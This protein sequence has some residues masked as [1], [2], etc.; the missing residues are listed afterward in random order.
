MN[1]FKIAEDLSH[2]TE[3]PVNPWRYDSI[4]AFL[5]TNDNIRIMDDGNCIEMRTIGAAIAL[6]DWLTKVIGDPAP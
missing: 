2:N 6:R 3:H 1:Q 5:S 4:Q